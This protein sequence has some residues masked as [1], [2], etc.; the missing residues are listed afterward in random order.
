MCRVPQL[1]EFMRA[2]RADAR[3]HGTDIIYGTIRIIERDDETVLAWARQRWACIVFNLHVEHSPEGIEKAA[4]AL[5]PPDRSRHRARRQLLPDLSPLGDRRAGSD[6][7]SAPH[8]FLAGE[9][10]DRSRR[11][12]PS[13]WFT[14]HERLFSEAEAGNRV[15][16][17]TKVFI[18]RLHQ[19]SRSPVASIR[20][21]SSLDATCASVG[22]RS[23][24]RGAD[25]GALPRAR[26]APRSPSSRRGIASAAGCTPFA[27]SRRISTPRP[28]P[29]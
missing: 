20:R 29:T 14:H 21:V 17:I 12:V 2:V 5:P 15:N 22:C 7:P 18:H 10:P 4:R 11:R 24:T 13:D 9:A 26:R 8:E 1:P 6:L 23:G 19:F 28:V 16:E 25:G 27:A 3:Q